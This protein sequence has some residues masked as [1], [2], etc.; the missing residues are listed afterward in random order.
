M[1][2]LN[3]FILLIQLLYFYTCYAQQSHREQSTIDAFGNK[4]PI[5]NYMPNPGHVDVDRLEQIQK[6]TDLREEE[7]ILNSN[8]NNSSG[9][10]HLFPY[11]PLYS[12]A[13]LL[14]K[15]NHDRQIDFDFDF[16]YYGFRFN[17]SMVIEKKNF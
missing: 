1:T 4:N 14:S 17:Y 11:G 12:D 16:P 15:P 9:W 5:F 10:W 7:G 2:A 13:N 6:Y 8:Y 3:R